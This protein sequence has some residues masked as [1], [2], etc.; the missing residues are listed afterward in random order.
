MKRLIVFVILAAALVIWLYF[1]KDKRAPASAV[2]AAAATPTPMPPAPTPAP[3]APPP[4]AARR[5][6]PTRPQPAQR[7][8][9]PQTDHRAAVAEQ[10][11]RA[12][13]ELVSYQQTSNTAIIE[14]RWSSDNLT[15]GTDVVDGLVKEGIVRDFSQ[16]PPALVY[17]HTPDGRRQLSTKF[18]LIFY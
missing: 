12:R 17:G 2:A 7:A 4:A 11:R 9:A 15:Q 3:A 5:A 18:K 14:V 10:A 8:V 1:Q 16:V 13:V 6:E